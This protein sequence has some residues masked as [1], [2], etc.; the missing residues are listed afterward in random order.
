MCV[1]VCARVC[2][3]VHYVCGMAGL[4]SML[5]G[6]AAAALRGVAAAGALTG[7]DGIAAADAVG[8]VV[9]DPRSYIA[10][11]VKTNN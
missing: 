9:Q 2:A 6:A 1:C 7:V 4:T 3:C 10:S 11:G 5:A 8:W